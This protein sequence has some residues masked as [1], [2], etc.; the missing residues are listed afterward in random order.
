M[1]HLLF[2]AAIVVA[3]A[4]CVAAVAT[5]DFA[6]DLKKPVK[7]G[8]GMWLQ[9]STNVPY[10]GCNVAWIE[11][12]KWVVVIDSAFPRG[13]EAALASIKATTGGKPVKYVVVTPFFNI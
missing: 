6:D 1:K 12:D 2:R 3:L 10:W 7:V 4:G 13:A 8:P 5:Q 11:F 9:Q